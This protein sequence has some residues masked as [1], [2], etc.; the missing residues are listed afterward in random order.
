MWELKEGHL[1]YCPSQQKLWRRDADTSDHTGARKIL[2][3]WHP[4]KTLENEYKLNRNEAD[5][6]TN[7]L[8]TITR[9]AAR[10]DY[11]PQVERG[12]RIDPCVWVR[13]NGTV[14]CLRDEQDL[15]VTQ[16]FDTTGMGLQSVR[17]AERICRWLTVDEDSAQNLLRMFATPWLEP[18]KQLSYVFSGHGGDGKTL[19]MSQAVLA[20]LGEH[21]VFPSLNT[22]T[23]C[24]A[25]GYSLNRESMN[26]AMDGMAFAYDDEAGEVSESMLPMLRALSTGSTL[27]ARVT[28]GRY[29]TMRPTATIV[30]LTNQGFADSSEASD[31]R[32]FIKVEFH[33]SKDRSYEEYHAIE[34]FCQT[35]PAAFFAASCRLWEQGDEPNIVNLSPARQL[36]DEAFW[37]ISEII[38]NEQTIGQSIAQKDKYRNEF[39]RPI[40]P[41][42]LQLLGL[43]NS[44][45]R[46]F[47]ARCRVARVDDEHRFAKYR[48]IVAQQ[49]EEDTIVVPDI[50]QPLAECLLPSDCGFVCNYVPADEHKVARNWKKQVENWDVDTSVKPDSDVYAVIPAC[51]YVVIDMDMP[52]DGGE[53]GWQIVNQQVGVYGSSAFPSTYLVRTPSGGVHAYYKVPA[54]LS[55]RLKNAAH[56]DGVPIDVRV[57]GKGYVI[58]AGSHVTAG[59]YQLC[60][61]PEGDVPE[62]SYRFQQWLF[63]TPGYVEQIRVEGQPTATHTTVYNRMIE[64]PDFT[65]IRAQQQSDRSIGVSN[66]DMSVIPEG[67]RNT[68]LHRWAFGRAMHYPNNLDQI[69]ADLYE[70]ARRSGLTE[71]EAQN[72]WRSICRQIGGQQ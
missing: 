48:Q 52:K 26:D 51:G 29:R 5:R 55:G 14:L 40:S 44:T 39:K 61:I 17:D 10:S 54:V 70:R 3:S 53:S 7:Y 43:K 71:S 24:A 9:E 68:Q 64:A 57:D 23:Y 15:A 56:P 66:V 41:S 28:G 12:V 46:A 6:Y 69:E 22:A 8:I 72:I 32:R 47:G 62:L 45:S 50:P 16:T 2:N 25:G 19:I 21:K 42:L 1:R 18:F 63:A 31:V 58:G 20:V 38:D 30:L 13:R 67:Q 65:Q 34:L 33:S 37:L 4:V 27:Q 11:F 35:H 36:S 59:D 60:D 49:D